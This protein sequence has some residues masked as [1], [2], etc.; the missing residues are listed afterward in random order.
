[1]PHISIKHFPARISAQHQKELI[2]EINA[3]IQKA[4]DVSLHAISISMEPVSPA[5]WNEEVYQPEIQQ[6]A[7]QLIQAPA[8]D[9]IEK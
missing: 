8:Y 6:K 3:S 5:N 7:E 4:F 9:K 1:M 2:A